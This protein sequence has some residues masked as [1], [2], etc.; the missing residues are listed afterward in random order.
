MDKEEARFILRCFRPDGADAENPDFAEAL[1]WAAKDR[2]LGEWLAR[3]RA[4]DAAFAA[5]LAAT[6]IPGS[7]RHE[8]LAGLAAER[9]DPAARP[10]DFDRAVIGALSGITPPPGL[11][12]EIL[13]AMARTRSAP[14]RRWRLGAPLAAAAGIAL[15]FLLSP[16]EPASEPQAA[17]PAPAGAKTPDGLTIGV[18]EAGFIRTYESPGFHLEKK[19]PDLHVLF[20]HLRSVQ[21]PCPSGC[22]PKGLRRAAG[23]GCRELEIAGRRGAVV[24]FK[25]DGETLHLVVFKRCDVKCQLPAEGEPLIVSHG[26]WT[27]ARWQRGDRVFVLMGKQGVDAKRLAEMF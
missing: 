22:L 7:L 8:I 10:D 13:A 9:G 24:C 15:A 16:K 20:R 18:V 12:E 11:R 21:L 4:S 26:E 2:E 25:N 27:A 14:R 1:A 17:A 3:E 23:L 6:D 5:A 19:D